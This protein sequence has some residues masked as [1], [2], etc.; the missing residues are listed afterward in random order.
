MEEINMKKVIVMMSTYNGEK[1]LEEQIQSILNQKGVEVWLMIRDDGS[2]DRTKNILKQYRSEDGN[3][4]LINGKN[5]GVGASF[6]S[7]L[8]QSGNADY[9]AFADQDDIW[10]ENKLIE[11]IKKIESSKK[12]K[13]PVLYTSN[14]MLVDKNANRIGLRYQAIP[15]IDMV[16]LLNDNP[17]SGCTMILN[18]Y[19]RDLLIEKKARPGMNFFTV[20]I[21]DAWIALFAQCVGRI[22]YDERA[23]ILYRQHEENV[24]GVKKKTIIRNGKDHIAVLLDR[25]Q[26]NYRSRSA[27]QLLKNIDEMIV[28]EDT[29]E[30]LKLFSELNTFSGRIAFCKS[31]EI[32][33]NVRGKNQFRI[34]AMLGLL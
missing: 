13:S 32:M 9:Y 21:H 24:V 8:Y 29:L 34:K 2:T 16:N 27:C 6:M 4:M 20:R 26:G 17:F 22:I 33:K 31:K 1:Y 5:V 18:R 10:M 14:Q 3:I 30:I 28:S 23:F 25:N 12:T 15:K 11:G 7:L 19:L